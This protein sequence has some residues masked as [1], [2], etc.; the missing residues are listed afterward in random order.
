MYIKLTYKMLSWL[1]QL[2]E[3][4]VFFCCSPQH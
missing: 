2:R 4:G 1:P 3:W